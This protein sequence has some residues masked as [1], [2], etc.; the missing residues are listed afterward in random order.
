M[1]NDEQEKDKN[2]R[3]NCTKVNMIGLKI[4]VNFRI[5]VSFFVNI[6]ASKKNIST[7]IKYLMLQH[8]PNL[9]T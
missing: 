4:N 9:N 3:Y 1:D 2:R 6:R 7:L 5:C 8:C